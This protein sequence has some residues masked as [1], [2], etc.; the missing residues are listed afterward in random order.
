MPTLRYSKSPHAWNEETLRYFKIGVRQ[1]TIQEFF[2]VAQ[3]PPP[4]INIPPA[5]PPAGQAQVPHHWPL[6]SS[7]ICASTSHESGV[8]GLGYLILMSLDYWQFP[9][10]VN[11]EAE[12]DF[13]VAERLA[14]HGSP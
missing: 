4:A 11:G 10:F 6:R 8:D 5:H 7:I 12:A 14:D 2:E 3:L 9:R 13:A 1:A